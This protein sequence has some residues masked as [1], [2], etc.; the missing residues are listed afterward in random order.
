MR[1][2]ERVTRRAPYLRCTRGW[3]CD[4]IHLS[5]NDSAFKS[6]SDRR[7]MAGPIQANANKMK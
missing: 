6:G 3:K 4:M 2:P 1:P 5:L 7:L